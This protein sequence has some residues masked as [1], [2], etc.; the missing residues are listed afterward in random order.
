MDDIETLTDEVQKFLHGTPSI[1]ADTQYARLL[2]NRMDAIAMQGVAR[3]RFGKL[4]LALE[5]L[6]DVRT[7]ANRHAK[8]ALDRVVVL[9]KRSE[10]WV[11]WNITR[12]KES[13]DSIMAA[14]EGLLTSRQVAA[15]ILNTNTPSVGSITGR[16]MGLS[17]SDRL[18]VTTLMSKLLADLRDVDPT[19]E[20]PTVGRAIIEAA[21]KSFPD[22]EALFLWSTTEGSLA[23]PASPFVGHTLRMASNFVK[24]GLQ[25][26]LRV[27]RV[28][29]EYVTWLRDGSDYVESLPESLKASFLRVF[30][31]APEIDVENS[32]ATDEAIYIGALA[33][34]I[35]ISSGFPVDITS[36]VVQNIVH[37]YLNAYAP[38]RDPFTSPLKR[39]LWESYK[40][41]TQGNF[42]IVEILSR[43]LHRLRSWVEAEM[44]GV[45]AVTAFVN[46]VSTA[47]IGIYDVV[48]KVL[49]I[50]MYVIA[51]MSLRLFSVLDEYLLISKS[52][53]SALMP[54]HRRRR[55]AVWAPLMGNVFRYFSAGEKFAIGCAIMD[56]PPIEIEYAEWAS[57]RIDDL[58]RVQQNVVVQ[59][60]PPVRP[61]HL[62]DDV[63]TVDEEILKLAPLAPSEMRI[64]KLIGDWVRT[65]LDSGVPRGI[66]GS[67]FATG[68]RVHKSISRYNIERPEADEAVRATVIAAAHAL[69]ARNPEMYKD[70]VYLTPMAALRKVKVKYSPGLPFIPQFKDRKDVA[71]V[72]LLKASARLAEEYLTSGV[73]PGT[74]GH[75][76]P[77]MDVVKLEALLAGKNIRTV[78]AQ[79][80]IGNIMM[81]TSTVETTRRQAPIDAWVMNAVPRSEGGFRPFF[82][83]LEKRGH[84]MATD[85]HQYDSQLAPVLT[86]DGLVELRSLGF[87]DSVAHD[88]IK[89]QI[90]ANYFAY[91]HANI[92]NV[93]TGESVRKTGGF[94]TGGANTSPDNRDSFRLMMMA[95]WSLATGK[96]PAEFF[97]TNTL[98]NAGDDNLV[99]TDEPAHVWDKI[100]EIC[101]HHFGVTMTRDGEGFKDVDLVGLGVIDTPIRSV[102]YYQRVGIPVPKWSIASRVP[103][104]MMKRTEMTWRVAKLRDVALYMSHLNGIIG[105]ALLTAHIHDVYADLAEQYVRE[106]SYVL[107]RFWETVERTDERDEDGALI[108][109]HL[110]PSNVR[111]RY[112]K[113]NLSTI[114]KWL[115]SHRYP[116]YGD[117][118]EIWLRPQIVEATRM[119]KNHRK[120]LTWNP[121]IGR[122][123]RVL[124]GIMRT[125][126][127]LWKWIPSHV[128][129]ALPEFTGPDITHIMR[130]SDY[131][132]SKFVWLSL[133]HAQG[134]VPSDSFYRQVLRENPYASA[135]D[136]TGFLAWLHTDDNVSKL[137]KENLEAHRGRVAIA[138]LA[139]TLM[140][141]GLAAISHAPFFGI[142]VQ[143]FILGTRD[144]NRLYSFANHIHMLATGRSS[145]VISN[146][147]PADPYA[148]MK[149]MSVI[150]AAMIPLR[151]CGLTG[152]KW[153]AGVVPKMV[154]IWVAAAIVPELPV[155]RHIKS[156]L[157][158][159]NRWDEIC[160]QMA[161]QIQG[162]AGQTAASFLIVAPTGTGKSTAFVAGLR[163]YVA[164]DAWVWVL[165]PT[166]AARDGYQND[167]IKAG[168]FQVLS[169]GVVNE[170]ARPVK[171]LTYMHFLTGRLLEVRPKDVVVFDEMHL[172]KP[173][174][175]AV[176]QVCETVVR[177]QITATPDYRLQPVTDFAHKYGEGR[178]FVVNVEHVNGELPGLVQDLYANRPH[179]LHRALIIA[180]TVAM[181][182]GIVLMLGRLSLNAAV[183]S[184]DQPTPPKT[185]VVVG[186]TIVDTAV[187]IEPPPTCLI[188]LGETLDIVSDFKNFWP[189]Y[190]ANIVA[191]SPDT[192][193]QRLGRVG[194]AGNSIAFVFPKSGTGPRPTVV[195][196]PQDVLSI[197]EVVDTIVEAYGIVVMVEPVRHDLPGLLK[198]LGLNTDRV[199]ASSTHHTI[200]LALWVSVRLSSH[201]GLDQVKNEWL[202]LRVKPSPHEVVNTL[203]ENL[204]AAYDGSPLLG[205]WSSAVSII[206]SGGV[207]CKCEGEIVPLA[208]LVVENRRLGPCGHKAFVI[209][210]EVTSPHRARSETR[211]IVGKRTLEWYVSS[212]SGAIAPPE[213]RPASRS[214]SFVPFLDGN[215]VQPQL[216]V[217]YAQRHAHS[218]F[219]S[220]IDYLDIGAPIVV[221]IAISAEPKLRLTPYGVRIDIDRVSSLVRGP[222]YDT[223]LFDCE[224]LGAQVYDVTIA[225][226]FAASCPETWTIILGHVDIKVLRA[227]Q[228][229]GRNMVTRQNFKA[230]MV[231][232]SH[233]R[234]YASYGVLAT[235]KSIGPIVLGSIP[236]TIVEETTD[237]RE[238]GALYATI[239]EGRLRGV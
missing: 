120:L 71:K 213:E 102:P 219:R 100:F 186:T 72:G 153:V 130:N 122:S 83:E 95:A 135:C 12:S 81:Y 133:Y 16:P 239:V 31:L 88:V 92:I 169:K 216:E 97:V 140:E 98:G 21:F 46:V 107:L 82:E 78:V 231:R 175:F 172:G 39:W 24:I 25:F 60:L 211:Y 157:N 48:D 237:V 114:F 53:V 105:S 10:A 108:A 104:L 20:A 51:N 67:W 170:P 80:L 45:G 177:V 138:T 145:P 187:T 113:A 224:G 223:V 207:F 116:S 149:Q 136:P 225:L 234:L 143:L 230:I 62:P 156:M 159:P 6:T 36:Q 47:A 154:D 148:W 139:Y 194:R 203:L 183:M 33:E 23:W 99:G 227:F 57:R 103:R 59:N 202:N 61:M 26:M 191:V 210:G 110:E 206:D 226:L 164:V 188:D 201:T 5:D 127:L 236:R 77:K 192:A 228:R 106:A 52:F 34:T 84:V 124:Y 19:P 66:D 144:V 126:E 171:V 134:K 189:E 196:S 70:A 96:D 7:G 155:A 1:Q 184:S 147:M 137:T 94:M 38:A 229:S 128:V 150:I 29:L 109:V 161:A 90:R 212:L 18:L 55:K 115:K 35:L 165:C 232:P 3:A 176:W 42:K 168:D 2:L 91:T 125:R 54:E 162:H 63:A 89:S 142:V 111:S 119:A 118:M 205:D 17:D 13:A 44:L 173:E 182:E 221:E 56:E 74:V 87:D 43:E 73:H 160:Q 178:R 181:A 208:C 190:K 40:G 64:D 76:F 199:V 198:Y 79:E 132:I 158:L 220:C 151:I 11:N 204:V 209:G 8:Q 222:V 14:C 101:R 131:V 22:V 141:V 238:L 179:L 163:A 180:P 58:N 146:M 185:G 215:L 85:G 75:A 4:A 152:V 218:A 69:A 41:V 167:F 121:S 123:D 200:V 93:L 9:V 174:N 235:F 86:I 27:P 214:R 65:W 30:G 217:T 233:A 195:P 129:K 166:I 117:V 197:D 37:D 112:K 68:E 15:Y 193:T 49:D 32:P 50:V 28:S